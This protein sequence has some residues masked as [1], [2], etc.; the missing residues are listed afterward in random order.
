[1]HEMIHQYRS[2]GLYKGSTMKY[3]VGGDGPSKTAPLKKPAPI[4]PTKK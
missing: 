1:M 4:T 2:C 3:Q